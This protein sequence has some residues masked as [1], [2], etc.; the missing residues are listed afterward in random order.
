MRQFNKLK[1]TKDFIT[2]WERGLP[3]PKALGKNLMK[4]NI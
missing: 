4:Y 3:A 1:G 2:I